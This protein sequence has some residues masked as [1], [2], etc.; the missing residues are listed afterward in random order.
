M[1][2]V[3][4]RRV[5]IYKDGG[6]ILFRLKDGTHVYQDFRIS[7]KT[8]GAFF[9]KYPN[10]PAAKIIEIELTEET[11]EPYIPQRRKRF[12]KSSSTS[13]SRSSEET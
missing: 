3:V 8:R 5:A 13:T 6:T 4:G 7:T 11:N 1:R 2:K 10:S 9:N 12:E